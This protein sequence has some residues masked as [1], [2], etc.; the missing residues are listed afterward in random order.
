MGVR[1]VTTDDAPES[2]RA[3]SG[4]CGRAEHRSPR[5]PGRSLWVRPTVSVDGGAGLSA[6]QGAHRGLVAGCERLREHMPPF[7]NC[8][9]NRA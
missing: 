9:V 6:D 4:A 5:G 3:S 7:T 2:P 8:Q 1:R